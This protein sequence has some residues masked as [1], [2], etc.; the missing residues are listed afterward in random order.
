MDFVGKKVS[1]VKSLDLELYGLCELVDRVGIAME[2]HDEP[3]RRKKNYG[4]YVKISG[5]P[6]KDEQTWFIPLSALR[7]V[8]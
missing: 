2:Q 4:C 7:V 1:I 3:S 8:E 6:Y 5:D